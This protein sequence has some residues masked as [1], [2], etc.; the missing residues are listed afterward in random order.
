M[1]FAAQVTLAIG[2]PVILAVLV[3]WL[4]AR[5]MVGVAGRIRHLEVI[6]RVSL[7]A[8]H[9]LHLVRVEDKQLVVASGPGGCT[10]LETTKATCDASC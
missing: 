6:E 2:V 8:Q 9:S 5:G 4:K 7:T 10:L 3:R 1:E